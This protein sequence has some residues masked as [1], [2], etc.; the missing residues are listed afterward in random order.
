MF[1]GGEA[2]PGQGQGGSV[3][4]LWHMVLPR[5]GSPPYLALTS[6]SHSLPLPPRSDAAGTLIPANPPHQAW[7]NACDKTLLQAVQTCEQHKGHIQHQIF[8]IIFNY[9][10]HTMLC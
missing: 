2:G 9:N 5:V 4:G 6:G 3:W 7:G 8:I 10:G 1:V